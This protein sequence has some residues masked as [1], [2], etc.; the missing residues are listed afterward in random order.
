MKLL[1]QPNSQLK[2]PDIMTKRLQIKT[3]HANCPEHLVRHSLVLVD[4]S[5]AQHNLDKASGLQGH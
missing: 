5:A 4:P 1:A 2:L 3:H